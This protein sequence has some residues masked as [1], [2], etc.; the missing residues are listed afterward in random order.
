MNKK[1][2]TT[3][4]VLFLCF[5]LLLFIS[6]LNYSSKSFYLFQQTKSVLN[7]RTI[8]ENQSVANFSSWGDREWP[9]KSDF[10]DYRDLQNQIITKR[11]PQ[12]VV[13]YES[14]PVGYGNRVFSMLS[15]LMIALVTDSALIIKWPSIDSFINCSLPNVFST[16][17]DRSFLDFKQK[18][19]RI[20]QINTNTPNTWSFK[21]QIDFLQ[22]KF[23]Q[24]SI[25]FYIAIIIL[26]NYLK[27]L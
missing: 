20:C 8:S 21:K 7:S 22:G 19:P 5:N 15:S 26:I 12:R 23:F 14:H 2:V 11:T 27:K 3:T 4:V 10:S 16:Y 9:L 24:I 25:L 18:S 1:L 13:F 17:S 6:Q